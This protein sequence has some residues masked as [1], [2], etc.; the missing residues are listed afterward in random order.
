MGAL[1]APTHE[2]RMNIHAL[3]IFDP[4]MPEAARI[5]LAVPGYVTE[6]DSIAD[7]AE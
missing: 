3:D 7:L 2:L 1:S 5:G 4:H 6:V